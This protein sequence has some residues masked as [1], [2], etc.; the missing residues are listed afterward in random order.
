MTATD[1]RTNWVLGDHGWVDSGLKI[2]E[3]EVEEGE[4]NNEGTEL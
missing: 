1:T 2:E 3:E 4:V